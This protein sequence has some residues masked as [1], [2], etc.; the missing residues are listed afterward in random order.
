MTLRA[1]WDFRADSHTDV[2]ESRWLDVEQRSLRWP[3]GALGDLYLDVTLG[4]LDVRL[5]KQEIRWGRADGFNPTDNLTP[6]DYL[7]PFLARRIAVPAAKAD[8]QIGSS[9]LEAAWIPFFTPTRLPLLNKRWFPRLPASTTLPLG[10]FG[11][12]VPLGVT[13][14]DGSIRFPARTLANGQWGVR[15]NQL[16]PRGELSLSYFDGFDDVASF[17]GT[18]EVDLL[19]PVLHAVAS[20]NREYGRLRVVGFDFATELGPVGIR[21]E[22]AGFE[23]MNPE[24][25]D[26]LVYIV[27]FD[28][29]WSAWSVV[30]EYTDRIGGSTPAATPIFPDLGLKSTLL[31]RTVWT[32]GRSRSIEVKGALRLR[33]GDFLLQ[34]LYTVALTDV[35]RLEVSAMVIA[36]SETGY[37]GQYRNNDSVALQLRYA[38]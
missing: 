32:V 22:V 23:E 2:D 34:P 7:D 27:G 37:F 9:S 36:G 16:L 8:V 33:D 5:G 20:L 6:F 35:W 12:Q 11:Q 18:T 28:R 10:P 3:A 15:W 1:S 4:R 17:R 38:F 31:A 19:A 14:R 25:R 21:G 26:R 30:V 13:Y 24:D 29:S